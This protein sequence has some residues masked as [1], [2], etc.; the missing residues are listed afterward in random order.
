M[1][2]VTHVEVVRR[3]EQV[4]Q[5]YRYRVGTVDLLGAVRVEVINVLLRAR[6]AQ[7]AEKRVRP[8]L[9]GSRRVLLL[10]MADE[11]NRRVTEHMPL[12]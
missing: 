7:I 8:L 5:R 1:R 3:R 2:A 10:T 9:V 4:P 6:P 12:R 11:E